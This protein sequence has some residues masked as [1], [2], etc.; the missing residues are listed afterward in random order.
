MS[1]QETWFET[2]EKPLSVDKLSGFTSFIEIPN[3][4]NTFFD[5]F[6]TYKSFQLTEAKRNIHLLTKA[7]SIINKITCKLR[8]DILKNC[9]MNCLCFFCQLFLA[10]PRST[11]A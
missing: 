2:K 1:I 8:M 11:K 7:A 10:M 6:C 9:F 3:V 4:L 5:Q